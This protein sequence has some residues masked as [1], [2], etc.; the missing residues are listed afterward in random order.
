MGKEEKGKKRLISS[1]G[2]YGMHAA[3][4]SNGAVNGQSQ[5]NEND[6]EE[7]L[8][9]DQ[10]PNRKGFFSMLT[11]AIATPIT[12]FFS[13]ISPM[14]KGGEKRIPLFHEDEKEE[15]ES[16]VG[17]EEPNAPTHHHHH[18]H[19]EENGLDYSSNG[20]G[21]GNLASLDSPRI[22]H[23]MP[24]KI[25]KASASLSGPSSSS[26]V[27][28]PIIRDY[29]ARENSDRKS[30]QGKSLLSDYFSRRKGHLNGRETDTCL[31]VLDDHVSSK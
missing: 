17:L 11:S 1:S 25:Q 18:H 22:Q 20:R 8:P 28:A 24:G 27:K 26:A 14:G 19:R 4:S 6:N 31:K 23:R 13:R 29:H 5:R 2:P 3:M 10:T 15:M 30:S 12:D 7:T 16:E 9:V 21:I